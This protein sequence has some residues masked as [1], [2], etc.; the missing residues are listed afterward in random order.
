MENQTIT[1]PRQN[2]HAAGFACAGSG[3]IMGAVV[4]NLFKKE[5]LTTMIGI[6]IGMI[7]TAFI[8]KK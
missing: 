6:G 1:M 2:L 3:I 4:L 8:I 7:I 5:A